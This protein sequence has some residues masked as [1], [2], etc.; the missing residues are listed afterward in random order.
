MNNYKSSG[1]STTSINGNTIN[2]QAYHI[3]VDNDK[4]LI[5]TFNNGDIK[6]YILDKKE[7][8]EIFKYYFNNQINNSSN[9]SLL[10]HLSSDYKINIEP[11]DYSNS[12]KETD[13]QLKDLYN[14]VKNDGKSKTKKVKKAKGNKVK[15]TKINKDKKKNKKEKK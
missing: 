8:N 5:K 12:L 11:K 10:N 2:E 4:G 14:D 6:N 1:F 7:V 15:K 13:S 9:K 3:N